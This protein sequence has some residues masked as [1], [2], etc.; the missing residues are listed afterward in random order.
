MT[1]TAH[2]A[3]AH[4]H[5]AGTSWIDKLNGPWH[6]R[7]NY[8]FMAV[9]LAHW[10][11]H[12]FQAYQIYVMG[13]PVPQSLGLL[14]YIYPWLVKSEALH[15]GYALVMLTGLWT[16]RHGFAGR[17]RVW[18][19]ASFYIQFWHHFEHLILQVQAIAGYNL[20]GSPVPISIVQLFIRRV[21]LHLI[22]NGAV[23]LPMVVAVWYHLFP[24]EEEASQMTCSCALHTEPATAAEA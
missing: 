8:L 7:A 17:A 23:F 5:S 4:P 13:W 15:Y 21:E 24:T 16:L 11:E 1:T 14:G 2:P 9:V 18:W 22:Y 20:F 10:G 19:M 6:E 12:L 3:A